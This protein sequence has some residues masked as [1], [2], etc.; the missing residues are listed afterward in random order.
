M[1]ETP[2]I[3]IVLPVYTGARYLPEALASVAAQ[4]WPY[5]ELICVD[6]ASTDET[7]ALLSA[8]AARDSRIRALRH[9]RNQ[10]LPAALNT[11]FAA[12]RGELFTWTSDDNRYRPEALATLARRLLAEP[13]LAFVY[14][15]YA[16][17]DDDG[18]TTGLNVAPAPEKL[19][20]SIDGLPC[21]LYR[22]SV[23]ERVGAHATDLFLA[24]DYDYVLR[25]I[26][27]G[28]TLT[29]IHQ[30]LYEYRRHARSLTDTYRGATFAVAERALLRNMPDLARQY[31]EE[32]GAIYLHL[33]SL[34]AWH[35]QR[36]RA[37][38][39]AAQGARYHPRAAALKAQAYIKRRLGGR[40]QE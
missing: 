34:A 13:A 3:S 31:P 8:W 25:V 5:W 4:T 9:E 19:I 29:P 12:A 28:Y 33:A 35:G 40:G 6:D 26:A 32:R 27:A 1:S 36:L 11:G 23:Y 18:R 22:R 38:R 10:R 15:D 20:T 2:L 21:F 37:I 14:S 17:L 16:L 39:Y 24:E 7:P 30:T